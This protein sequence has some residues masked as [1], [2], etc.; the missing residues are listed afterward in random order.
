MNLIDDNVFGELPN[1]EVFKSG[2]KRS[3]RKPSYGY[4][5]GAII[6][7]IAQRYEH[8]HVKYDP[9]EL[10]A[11]ANWKRAVEGRDV[12]FCKQLFTHAIDHLWAEMRGI[13]DPDSGGN[14]GA[15]G[16]GLDILAYIKCCDPDL[17]MATRGLKELK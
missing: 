7:L 14:L 3:E 10:Y 6:P 9:S 16:W 11:E 5:N 4:M 8:G 2:A 15:V 12:E 13:D 1:M 17:Y